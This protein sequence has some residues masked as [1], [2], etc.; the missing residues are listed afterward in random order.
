M[1]T[2]GAVLP[3]MF[4]FFHGLRKWE[5]FVVIYMEMEKMKRI[6]LSRYLRSEIKCKCRKTSHRRQRVINEF[7]RFILCSTHV[8]PSGTNVDLRA[9]NM[10][11]F[12]VHAERNGSPRLNRLVVN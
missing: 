12:G 8:A 3:S 9:T 10:S 11:G 5:A 6:N 7:R 2:T 1:R 4:K